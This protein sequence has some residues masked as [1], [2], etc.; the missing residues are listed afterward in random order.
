[1]L[2]TKVFDLD[3]E[4]RSRQSSIYLMSNIESYIGLLIQIPLVGIF[5]WFSLQLI[6]IFLKSLDARDQQWRLFIEQERRANHEA[7]ANM[8]A[9][10]SDEIRVL[11]KEVSELRGQRQ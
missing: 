11:G 7:I 10:F 1:M 5:V 8:A 6:S 3:K 4:T 2:K 9:R